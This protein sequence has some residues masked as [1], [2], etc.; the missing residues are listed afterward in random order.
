MYK[1]T[2]IFPFDH[3]LNFLKLPLSVMLCLQLV[4]IFLIAAIMNLKEDFVN[5]YSHTFQYMAV[6]IA[7]HISLCFSDIFCSISMLFV[8]SEVIKIFKN[9]NGCLFLN[10]LKD[11]KLFSN[12]QNITFILFIILFFTSI[13]FS[14]VMYSY[15]HAAKFFYYLIRLL[16]IVLF[17]SFITSILYYLNFTISMNTKKIAEIKKNNLLREVDLHCRCLCELLAT[18]KLML[19]SIFGFQLIS[20]ITTVFIST[21]VRLYKNSLIVK[22]LINEYSTIYL[23]K[24]IIILA[25]P[26]AWTFVCIVVVWDAIS[27]VGKSYKLVIFFYIYI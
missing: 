2:G 7:S 3:N 9:I 17:K 27:S 26:V 1:L 22:A 20:L 4:S 13:L 16:R 11:E 23:E 5:E 24:I 19:N 6:T 15:Y 25:A 8:R 10:G 18:I 14:R 21:V 12:L